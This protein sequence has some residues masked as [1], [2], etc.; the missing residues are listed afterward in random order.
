MCIVPYPLRFY[1]GYAF[2]TPKSF[3]DIGVWIAL[4]S[5]LLLLT[6]AYLC[7]KRLPLL[8]CFVCFFLCCLLPISNVLALVAGVVAERLAFMA[9]LGFCILLAYVLYA[10][11][12]AKVFVCVLSLGTYAVLSYQRHTLW[13]S[14]EALYTHD[15]ATTPSSIKMQQLYASYCLDLAQKGIDV[16]NNWRLAQKHIQQALYVYP[17]G[18]LNWFVLGL[19]KQRAGYVEDAIHAYDKALSTMPDLAQAH[20]N[21]AAC[22]AAMQNNTHAIRGYEHYLKLV[23]D[24]PQAYANLAFLYYRQ[25]AYD[26]ALKVTQKACFKFP[27]NPDMWENKARI[28]LAKRDTL[29]ALQSLKK[30]S[31]LP[32]KHQKALKKRY[33]KLSK[34]A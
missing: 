26:K 28:Y 33:E 30:A 13:R 31:T 1:Y 15:V 27:N 17:H 25:K 7:R 22:L 21:K 29:Q 24:A 4:L 10:C 34:Q 19:T 2:F 23:P 11:G 5:I 6:T 12:K 32:S 18:A 8:A 9:S 14:K 16:D 20:F 3:T